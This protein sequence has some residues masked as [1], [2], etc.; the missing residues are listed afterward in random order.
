PGAV[1]ATVQAAAAP[2]GLRYGP[3][4]STHTRCTVGGMIGNNACGNRALGYGRTADNIVALDLVTVSGERLQVGRDVAATSPRL[5][6]LRTL[7]AGDLAT[8]R[9]EFGR[10]GR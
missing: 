10:F 1:H 3:D 4:P 5:E 8:V 2:F 7:V 9:T 6:E